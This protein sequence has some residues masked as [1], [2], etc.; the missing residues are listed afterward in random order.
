[1]SSTAQGETAVKLCRLP[2]VFGY[3]TDV[4]LDAVRTLSTA[5][6]AN[7]TAKK[8]SF[9]FISIVLVPDNIFFFNKKSSFP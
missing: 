7:L 8:I 3:R 9:R 6:F 4:A 5:N 2:P 1:M